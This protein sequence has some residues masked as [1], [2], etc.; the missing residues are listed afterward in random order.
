MS[1]AVLVR[2]QLTGRVLPCCWDDCAQ[3]GDDRHAVNVPH[4]APRFPGEQLRYVFCSPRHAAYWKH[5][6]RDR[7]N[8]PTGSRGLLG[9]LGLPL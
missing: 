3:P 8:L 7:G 9:P 5:S 2:N 1:R 4:D 6:H